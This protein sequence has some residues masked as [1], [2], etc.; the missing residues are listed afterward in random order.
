MTDKAYQDH[1]RS[2]R[3]LGY[4]RLL[5]TPQWKSFRAGILSRDKHRCL[6]CNVNKATEVHHVAYDTS[7]KLKPWEY[8]ENLCISLC[9]KCH[10]QLHAEDGHHYINLDPGIEAERERRDIDE[11]EL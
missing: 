3:R 5:Q 6:N 8:P 4:K 2:L 9:S 7:K 1:L 10:R 11:I